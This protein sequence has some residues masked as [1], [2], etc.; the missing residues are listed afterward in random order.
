MVTELDA[1]I[2]LDRN[3]CK[4]PIPSKGKCPSTV[5]AVPSKA[6]LDEQAETYASVMRFCRNT[7]NC[8]GV[9]T[10]GVSDPYSWIG[11]AAYCGYGVALP[12]S[13][14]LDEN[15]RIFDPKPAYCK[16]MGV[17]GGRCPN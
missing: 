13:G 15:Q 2:C 5:L 8:K 6:E 11:R 14:T 12:F 10:W 9:V 7:D 1:G 4:Y 3:K 17:I 16:M